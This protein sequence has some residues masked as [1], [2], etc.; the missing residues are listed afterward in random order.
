M[1]GPLSRMRT[2]YGYFENGWG[3]AH[4]GARSEGDDPPPPARKWNPGCATVATCGR[5]EK[6]VRV[7]EA[8]KTKK[9]W[10]QNIQSNR[11]QH[12]LNFVNPSSSSGDTGRGKNSP[13]HRD[14]GSR[15]HQT[16]AARRA[17]VNTRAGEGLR[18]TH[19]EGGHIIPPAVSA[20]RK[21]GN[22]ELR[23]RGGY[24]RIRILFGSIFVTFDQHFQR[25]M[26]SPMQNFWHFWLK[27]QGIALAGLAPK[28]RRI[29]SIRKSRGSAMKWAIWNRFSDLTSGQQFWR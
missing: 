19:P 2:E 12:R 24:A 25:Q 14:T 28:P 10:I 9:K 4:N 17:R 22:T 16:P 26:T 11:T 5:G 27:V 1:G 18:I 7:R 6:V 20:P 13:S 8:L 15:Y 29:A 23:L 3:P 21:A